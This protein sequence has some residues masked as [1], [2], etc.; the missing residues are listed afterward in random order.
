MGLRDPY[1]AVL[2]SVLDSE[3]AVAAYTANGIACLLGVARP[4]LVA[5]D[6]R[7]WLIGHEDC[8]R[9]AVRFL[10]ESRHVLRCLEDAYPRLENWVD[11]DN[12]AT[13]RWLEW[14]GF[15]IDRENPV[16]TPMGFP[17][18]HVWKEA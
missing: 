16:I 13:L 17:F 1:Q 4:S 6:A 8:E 18:Y 10:K 7:I 11:R 12:A 5:E 3:V 14:L 2:E 9:Y 15:N